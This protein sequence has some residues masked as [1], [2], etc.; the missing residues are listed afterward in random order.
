MT[1]IVWDI[2]TKKVK[3]RT[4]TTN[5]V[6]DHFSLTFV[7]LSLAWMFFHVWLQKKEK[8][9][10]WSKYYNYFCIYQ[11]SCVSLLE[12]RQGTLSDPEAYSELWQTSKMECFA[13]IVN[14]DYTSVI[15]YW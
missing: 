4:E 6:V 2:G 12:P 9:L 3:E 13:K 1:F 14:F 5:L 15:Y 10:V 7:D 8:I 11:P